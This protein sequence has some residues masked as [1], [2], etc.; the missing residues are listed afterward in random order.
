MVVI[1][2][3]DDTFRRLCGALGSPQL[4]RDPRFL[5]NSDRRTNDTAL[6][7]A[8]ET[9]L[10]SRKAAEW[11]SIL[12]E[13]GVPC[14][15][16]C[17]VAEAVKNPQLRERK[18]IVSAGAIRMAGNPIKIGSLSDSSVRKPAPELDANGGKI[19]AEFARQK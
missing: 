14:A 13:A 19:R 15:V 2:G 7:A 16:V 10:R 8:I 5:T 18:M 9:I 11:E 1:S 3:N 17:T 12:A 4:G 6:N